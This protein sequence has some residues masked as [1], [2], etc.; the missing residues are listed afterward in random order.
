MN[1]NDTV[2]AKQVCVQFMR[3][4]SPP[5]GLLLASC[6]IY[7]YIVQNVHVIENI[8]VIQIIAVQTTKSACSPANHTLWLSVVTDCNSMV[9]LSLHR[10]RSHRGVSITLNSLHILFLF[11]TCSIA[12]FILCLTDVLFL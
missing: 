12:T 9:Y 3:T 2:P 1:R 6:N 4:G 11:C 10:R 8:N 5:V 7:E